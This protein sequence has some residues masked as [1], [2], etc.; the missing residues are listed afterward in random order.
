ME[1]TELRSE[2]IIYVL[3]YIEL[4]IQQTVSCLIILHICCVYLN[5][6]YNG[7][8]YCSNIDKNI[9]NFFVLP[10]R[11]NADNDKYNTQN[12]KKQIP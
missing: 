3:F 7:T 11:S 6:A 2:Y 4:I 12:Q 9:T 1:S 10:M 5:N 8:Q